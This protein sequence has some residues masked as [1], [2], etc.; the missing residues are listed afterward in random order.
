MRFCWWRALIQ[1]RLVAL[2]FDYSDGEILLE[3]LF[4]FLRNPR[5]LAGGLVCLGQS[6]NWPTLDEGHHMSQWVLEHSQQSAT[7]SGRK[8]Q[9][10]G[11]PCESWCTCLF[12]EGKQ[13]LQHVHF[14][15][16]YIQTL[17]YYLNTSSMPIASWRTLAKPI[18]LT[19]NTVRETTYIM[20]IYIYMH[21][22]EATNS[23]PTVWFNIRNAIRPLVDTVFRSA[24]NGQPGLSTL[25]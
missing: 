19:R 17:W 5:Q 21:V 20:Y 8:I 13:I 10:P 18:S 11:I 12:V 3:L 16:Q 7:T 14:V 4:V 9:C 25:S 2:C 1:I 22:F 15:E 23:I 6:L 24:W